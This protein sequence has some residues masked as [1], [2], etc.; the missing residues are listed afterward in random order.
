MWSS[1]PTGGND[2]TRFDAAVHQLVEQA[3]RSHRHH[4]AL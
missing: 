3:A 1:Y 2:T 4:P